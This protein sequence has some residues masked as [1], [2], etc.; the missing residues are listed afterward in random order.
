LNNIRETSGFV[1]FVITLAKSSLPSSL[2]APD[3]GLL[4]C[5]KLTFSLAYSLFWTKKGTAI[6]FSASISPKGMTALLKSS[7]GDMRRALNILQSAQVSIG[8]AE[9]S[10]EAIYQTTGAPCPADILQILDWLFNLDFTEAFNRY[11][12]LI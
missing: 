6:L 5:K 1:S 12:E 4:H 8:S 9:I 7:S 11:Y 10:E 3:L 2:D